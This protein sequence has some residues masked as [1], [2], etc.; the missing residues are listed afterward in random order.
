MLGLRWNPVEDAFSLSVRLTPTDPPTKRSVLSQTAR[1]FDPLGW[2]API[3]VRAKVLIQSTWLQQLDWD[4]PLPREDAAVWTNLEEELPVIEEVRLPRWLRCDARPGGVE[5]HGFSDA[6]E[7]AYAA[8]LYLRAETD[9]RINVHL[10]A[11]K[12]KVAPLKR[13]SLPRLELCGAA[14]L[15][16]LAEHVRLSLGLDGSAV[17]LWT[18]SSVALGWIRGHPAKWTTYVANRVAEIQRTNQDAVW[19]HVPGKENPADCASRGVSP[20]ELLH[21]PL[22][23]HGPNYLRDHCT[24]WPR[25]VGL[26][27]TTD[28]PEQR[29]PRCHVVVEVREP[30]ELCRFSNLRRLLRV[31][32]WIWRWR[33]RPLC[34]ANANADP[35]ARFLGPDELQGALSRW[36]RLAQSLS[37]GAELRDVRSGEPLSTGSPLRKLA[38]MLDREGILR[39]GGRLKHS[40]LDADQRHPIILPP[41]SH[42]TYLVIDAAHRRTLHGGIQAT[43]GE[44]R[45]R[46]WIPRGRQL[47]RRHLHR[48]V[49]CVRWR[50]ATPQPRM[51][52]LPRT[53]V[54]PSRPF[55]HTGVDL[56]GPVWLRT[57]K[58]RGHK[59]YKGFLVVFVCFS[60]RAVHLEA[61]SD[62]TAEAFLAAFRRFVARRG[63]CA[64]LHSDC[65]T[66]FVG[67]D[68]Q[69]RDL[70]RAASR[71]V[72]TIVGRL[73]DEGVRWCFNPPSAPHFGGLWEAAVKA[74]KHHLRR[75]IGEARLTF[76]EL[77]TFLAE[78]EACLN[79]RPLQALSDDPEDLNALT[80]GHFLVGG[81]LL[82]I[83]EPT[84]LDAPAGRLSRWRLLQQMRDHLWQRWTREY[85]Q[86]LT[87]RPK[88]WTGRGA[89][90]QGQLCL[91]K[92][93][94]TPPCLW[95]LARVT[96]LHPGEDGRVR[97]VGVRTSVGELT[98]PVV[99]IVP[100]PT[101]AAADLGPP[102]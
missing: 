47:V 2:L 99:K 75:T 67:A 51:G 17:H 92:G 64:T 44:I 98:R 73:A 6:S 22:W 56:A 60:S 48:C 11:A 97:V 34:A 102:A 87:P 36:V 5:L 77:T 53:R 49:T 29:P 65:G 95:P 61:V 69:L 55:L 18:D 85:L 39:V 78:V 52:D 59:A 4:A 30:D 94:A 83:P 33:T 43:L 15:A 70:F 62:Y 10:V 86:G 1:L 23:W 35:A 32:A 66:N 41:E 72:G 45:Q 81:P 7:R 40:V 74:V 54:T 88:W 31:S 50:A 8:V 28:L 84:L 93:E 68:R 16:K 42:L 101:A 46:H 90:Q 37:F 14:L 63:L 91:V 89:L 58:G 71:D 57:T 82:A 3:L 76:E 12:T 26:P 21:H 100:L 96:R 25:D 13:V 38:P 80:P 79:S 9:G 24:A 20:R 19:R 27:P